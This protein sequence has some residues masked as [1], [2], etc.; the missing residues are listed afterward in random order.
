MYQY[1]TA[2]SQLDSTLK[3]AWGDL[4][5][6]GAALAAW[7]VNDGWAK[8]LLVIATLM[9]ALARIY[10][11]L[12]AARVDSAEREKRLAEARKLDRESQLNSFVLQKAQEK[13]L[14]R[15]ARIEEELNERK[16]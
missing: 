13:L 4:P 8:D 5:A 3:Q 16:E 15:L 11:I 1:I 7:A 2:V 10:K 12:T 14:E 9:L 6:V